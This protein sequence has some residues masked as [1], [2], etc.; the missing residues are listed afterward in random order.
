LKVCASSDSG[1]IL[2]NCSLGKDRT[3]TAI[4]L[5]QAALGLDKKHIAENYSHSSNLLLPH[6]KEYAKLQFGKEMIGWSESPAL[7]ME[8]A[9]EHLEQKYGSLSNYVTSIGFNSKWQEKLKQKFLHKFPEDFPL[10][11]PL[12]SEEEIAEM[13]L[14]SSESTRKHKRRQKM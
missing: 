7:E 13:P 4:A 6:L 1:G 12:D 9:L 2:V 3:G 5:L 10:D 11:F 8:K 14:K